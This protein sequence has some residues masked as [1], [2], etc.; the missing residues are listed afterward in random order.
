MALKRV[1]GFLV[2]G[3]LT[4]AAPAAGANGNGRI[5]YEIGGSIYVADPAGGAPSLLGAGLEP[6]YSPDG[7]RIAYA[8]TPAGNVL[9]AHADGSNPV[10]AAT[11]HFLSPL[12]W[13][14]DGKQIA[15]ISGSYSSGFAVSVA[16]ADGSGSTVLS[17][18]AAS[19]RRRRGHRTEPSW[20]SRR[21]T[22]PI[23]RW[24]TPTEAAG[25]C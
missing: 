17:H 21:P 23:S 3:V 25:G 13:S 12:A 9:V 11:D 22:T 19:E 18:D 16:K 5:A 1:T 8:V 10:L 7:T 2:A 4:L 14:P 15:Y 6:T 20:P 24:L